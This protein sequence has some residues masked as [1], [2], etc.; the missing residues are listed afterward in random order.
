MNQLTPPGR[1][2]VMVFQGKNMKEPAYPNRKLQSHGTVNT[3]CE[4][5]SLP[6][7]EG[8]EP[9]YCENKI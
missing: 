4:G 3:K 5:T 9:W 1:C 6:R 2:I 8:P 7:Q